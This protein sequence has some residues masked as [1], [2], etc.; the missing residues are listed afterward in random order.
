MTLV[1]DFIFKS[2]LGSTYEITSLVTRI[3]TCHDRAPYLIQKQQDIKAAAFP[4]WDS[5]TF[6]VNPLDALPTRVMKKIQLKPA[7]AAMF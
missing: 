3:I 4:L 6:S 5:E 2:L 7:Y 1:P